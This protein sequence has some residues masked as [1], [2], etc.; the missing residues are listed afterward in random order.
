[1]KIVRNLGDRYKLLDGYRTVELIHEALKGVDGKGLSYEQRRD[2]REAFGDTG[3]RGNLGM[4]FIAYS[5]RERR[6]STNPLWRLTFPFWVLYVMLAIIV[7]LPL[8]WLLTGKFYFSENNP[9]TRFNMAW[10][11]KIFDRKW[12]D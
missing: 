3:S 1:M 5:W 7:V 11:N 10:Y 8:K 6:N 12:Y 9:L 2:L 4:P